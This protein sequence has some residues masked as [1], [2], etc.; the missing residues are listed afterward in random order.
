MSKLPDRRDPIGTKESKCFYGV[1]D[2]IEKQG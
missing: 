1:S 2:R